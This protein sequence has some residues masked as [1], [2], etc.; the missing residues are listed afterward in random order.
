MR[1]VDLIIASIEKEIEE[2]LREESCNKCWKR[3]NDG[4]KRTIPLCTICRHSK[5]VSEIEMKE[6]KKSV[7]MMKP[8]KFTIK[9]KF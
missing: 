3:K 6:K 2:R 9:K 8:V 4:N 1:G 7:M 5:G